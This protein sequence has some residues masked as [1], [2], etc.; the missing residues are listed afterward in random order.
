MKTIQLQ[1]FCT[2]CQEGGITNAARALYV[3]EPTISV[4]IRDLEAEYGISLFRR[5]KKRL[6]LTEEGSILYE[7]AKSMLSHMNELEQELHALAKKHHPVR[8]GTSPVSSVSVFLPIFSAF[9][10]A[11][12]EIE[13]EM[14]E[15]D[16]F[17]SM[18]ALETHRLDC[19]FVVEN[20]RAQEQFECI[21]IQ[22][23]S[24]LFCCGTGHRLADRKTLHITDLKDEKL[25]LPRP[26]GFITSNRIH[27]AFDQFGLKPNILFSTSNLVF[28]IEYM[29][30]DNEACSITMS[31]FSRYSPGIVS[32]PLE[33]TIYTTISYIRRKE[34][35]ISREAAVFDRFVREY[36]AQAR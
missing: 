24:M 35:E 12:P 29:R 15:G 30:M 22:E 28:Q 18:N 19:A 33:P 13:L 34:G 36:S 32:I 31:D 3:S 14:A 23:N 6:Y 9:R 21:P 2:V 8:V 17:Q 10:A 1:Y 20:T 7:R 27:S 4:A 5:E 16:A 11:H 25:I 26:G